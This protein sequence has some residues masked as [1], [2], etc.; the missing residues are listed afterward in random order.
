M[1]TFKIV[2]WL[3]KGD[4]WYFSLLRSQMTQ[5]ITRGG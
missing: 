3:G 1:V 4:E 2:E 5:M